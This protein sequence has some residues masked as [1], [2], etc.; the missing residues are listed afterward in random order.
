[1]GFRS[2]FALTV[3]GLLLAATSAMAHHAVQAQYDFD[4]PIEF[5]GVLVKM[6][7]INPHSMMHLEVTNKDG[8]KAL[9]LF[10]TTA[11]GALRQ[12]GLGQP[13]GGGLAVGHTSTATAPQPR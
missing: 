12:R 13:A 3:G 6:E 8:S 4:Q 1:M 10:Q 5:T 11:A 2:Y 9:W 7:W